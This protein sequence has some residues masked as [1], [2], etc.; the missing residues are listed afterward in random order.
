MRVIRAEV[1]EI[2]PA[3]GWRMAYLRSNLWAII[4]AAYE[5]KQLQ[6]QGLWR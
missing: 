6:I 5:F 2:T 3:L 4:P 1:G